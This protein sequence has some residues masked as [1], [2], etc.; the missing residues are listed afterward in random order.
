MIDSETRKAVFRLHERG[1]SIREMSRQLRMCRKIIRGIIKEKGSLPT[2]VRSDKSKIDLEL[3]KKHY[4]DCGG[5]IQRVHEK[6]KDDGVCVGYS[7]LTR[8]VRQMALGKP[9]DHRHPQ[10]PDQPGVEM[11]HDTSPYDVKIGEKTVRVAGSCLYF[12]YSKQRYLKF[13]PTFKRFRMKCFLHE[14]LTHFGYSAG[15]CIIDNTNLAD[16]KSVV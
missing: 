10:V 8:M 12:R 7:T 6:L 15:V 11:Q 14:A 13:Y 5:W 16:R 4:A 1:M 3:V 2:T 9:P